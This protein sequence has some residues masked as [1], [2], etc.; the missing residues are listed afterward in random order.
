[1][2]VRFKERTMPFTYCVR[3][4]N[5]YDPVGKHIATG[6]SGKFPYKNNP[7]GERIR[8]NG[9][10]P[11]G[12][13]LM[14]LAQHSSHSPPVIAL[15][16]LGHDARGRTDFRIH[17]DRRTRPGYASEGCIVINGQHVRRSILNN[18]DDELD[19]IE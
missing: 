10:I 13:Y 14:T 7:D 15:T 4:G 17:G 16:P 2:I 5:L 19:V 12:R 18:A 3:S 9:P 6:Y 11:K 8:D 1:M